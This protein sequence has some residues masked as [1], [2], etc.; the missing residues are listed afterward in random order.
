MYCS[1]DEQKE[2][3]GDEYLEIDEQELT[4]TLKAIKYNFI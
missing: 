1:A 2:L 3:M 4:E